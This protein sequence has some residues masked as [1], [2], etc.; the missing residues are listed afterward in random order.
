MIVGAEPVTNKS[1]KRDVPHD[2]S[3]FR[4]HVFHFP[5]ILN[6]KFQCKQESVKTLYG[7]KKRGLNK[8]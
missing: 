1:A 5:D 7:I 6:W 8:A 2:G 3:R 4:T